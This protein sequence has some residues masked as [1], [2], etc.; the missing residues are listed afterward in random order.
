MTPSPR[1]AGRSRLALLPLALALALGLG[2]A[3]AT[4]AA[5]RS[6]Y[7]LGPGDVLQLGVF[8]VADFARRVT[9]D[10]DGTIAVPFVGQVPAEGVTLSALRQTLTDDLVR[11]G[12]IQ[13]VD[14]TVEIVEYRPFYMAG[15]VARPGAVPFRPGLTV[16]HAVALAGG[17]EALRFRTENPFMAAPDLESESEGLWIDLLREKARIASLTAELAGKTGIDAQALG[18]SPLPA[19]TLRQIV[20]FEQRDLTLRLEAQ[21]RQRR[22]LEEGLQKTEAS[23]ARLGETQKRNAESMKIQ[24][25]AVDRLLGSAK[26]GIVSTVLIDD[27]RRALSEVRSRESEGAQRLRQAER[28]RDEM[29]RA[30]DRLGEE[31]HAGLNE[32]LRTATIEAEKLTA[33]LRASAEKLLY[34]G[35]ARAEL[36]GARGP[37]IRLHRLVDGRP[38]AIPA[39]EDTPIQPD[40][41]IEI[42]IHP[43]DNVAWPAN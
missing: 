43:E 1:R 29:R 39:R 20:A 10:I 35:A 11:D 14:V 12:R 30:L 3:T 38:Q 28:D 9:V 22:F 26:K 21:D 27:Q 15:D 36:G 4:L 24:Q 25:A 2:P 8:G 23:I 40:D 18:T 32:S 31:R 34:A 17:Y 6:P 7:R 42:A 16:R 37:E 33:R 41:V 5:E 19:A 13:T